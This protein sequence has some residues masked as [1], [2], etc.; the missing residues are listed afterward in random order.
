MYRQLVI[1]NS[2]QVKYFLA[3]CK[4]RSFSRAA[5][6][7]YVTQPSF[8]QFIKKIESETGAELIDRSSTPIRLTEA[9]EAYY[10]AC[11]QFAAIEEDMRSAISNISELKSGRLSVGATSF[12]ASTMLAKS[13]A[14][15]KREY[16][17]VDV[18]IAEGS[19]KYLENGVASGEIDLAICSGEFDGSIFHKEIL[20]DERLYMAVPQESEINVRLCEYRLEHSDITGNSLKILK[21]LPCS[22]A[23]F[24]DEPY[25]ALRHGESI[26]DKCEKIYE[27][28]H[29]SPKT[30]ISAQNLYTAVSFVL[31][32]VGCTLIPDTLIK[33]GNMQKHPCYYAIDSELTVNKVCLL[34]RKNRYLSR[35]AEEYSKI[36]KQLIRS[37]TWRI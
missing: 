28:A 1:M 29:L 20:S 33:Y 4:E 3:L 19:V 22:I 16:S 9:G 35:A 17:G 32:G 25:I 37:G 24:A 30:I 26:S 31:E 21:T 23:V 13:I 10:N 11:I 18:S 5:E 6:K 36:L 2:L 14:A 34:T 7:L 8:S 27:E 15:F 12:R